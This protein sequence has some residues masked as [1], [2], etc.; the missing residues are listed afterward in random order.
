MKMYWPV[1][2]DCLGGPGPGEPGQIA[3]DVRRQ[4]GDPV[5]HHVVAGAAQLGRGTG[6]A[7]VDVV[8]DDA[9]AGGQRVLA[10]LAAIQQVQLVAALD[11]QLGQRRADVPVPPMNRIFMRRSIYSDAHALRPQQHRAEVAGPLARRR[12]AQDPHRPGQAQVLRARHVPLPFGRGP[13]RRALRGLHRHRRHHP[14]EADAGV[15]RAASD[16]LGRLRSAGRE[17][18]H[19]ARRPPARHHRGGDRQLQAADRLRRLR[20][21]LGPRDRHHRSRLHEVDAVDLP[22]ALPA[23]PRLRGDH[24]HQLVPRSTRPASPTKR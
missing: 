6:P 18:R 17:L 23:R 12:P 13:A 2:A 7:A 22:A 20:L 10:A 9:D 5:D 15:P 3:L 1:V 24:P 11:H 16:G 8:V 4:E 14:L 21:R 19:Q